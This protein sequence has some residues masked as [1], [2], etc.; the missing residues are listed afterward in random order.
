VNKTAPT[1][2]VLLLLLSTATAFAVTQRL[3]LEPSPISQ[4]HVDKVFSPVCNCATKAAH[5]DFSIRLRDQ[6]RIWVRTPTGP[7]TIADRTFPKGT[8]HVQW[9]GRNATG[10]VVPDGIYYAVVKM[11]RAQRTIDLPNPIRVDTVKPTIVLTGMSHDGTNTLFRYRASEPAHA[12]LFVNGERRVRT[13]ST[14]KRGK[15]LFAGRLTAKT[16]LVLRARDVAGNLSPPVKIS[17]L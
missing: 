11:R 15:F 8:V 10:A 4:T 9:N 3:K 13:Y 1:V 7:V 16:R 5:I 2:L 6:L 14:R 17:S 12:L